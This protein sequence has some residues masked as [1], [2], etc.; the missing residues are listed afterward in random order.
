MVYKRRVWVSLVLLLFFWALFYNDLNNTIRYSNYVITTFISSIFDSPRVECNKSKFSLSIKGERISCVVN[1]RVSSNYFLGLSF[2][3]DRND[4]RRRSY[5]RNLVGSKIVLSSDGEFL[6]IAPSP[7]ISVEVY[8]FSDNRLVLRD[9]V[10]AFYV[11][12]EG[13]KE[14]LGKLIDIPLPIGKYRIFINNNV[15]L[16]EYKSI[17]PSF[18]FQQSLAHKGK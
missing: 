3:S 17:I 8:D 14:I 5:I 6:R 4:K 15:G 9:T 13:D 2:M 11:E 16:D 1:V 18:S 7:N 12:Y 10:S